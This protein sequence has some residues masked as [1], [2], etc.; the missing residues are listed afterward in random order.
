MAE[1]FGR[2]PFFF[3]NTMKLLLLR[4]VL[5]RKFLRELVEISRTSLIFVAGSPNSAEMATL[6]L[7]FVKR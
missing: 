1:S 5:E 2:S 6:F 7:S 3:K 4:I